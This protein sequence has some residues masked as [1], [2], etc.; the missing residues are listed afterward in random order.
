MIRL[1]ITIYLLLL[2]PTLILAAPINVYVRL[3]DPVLAKSVSEFNNELKRRGIFERYGFEP[4]L[5]RHPLHA[6]LYL[7]TYSKAR[8]EEVVEVA[9]RLACHS[10]P[11][12]LEITGLS[13]TNTNFVMLNIDNEAMPQ[14]PPLQQLS[15]MATLKLA[16]LR[17]Y[18]AHI[19]DWV[20]SIP[21]KRKAFER[22]GSPN[23]FF[24]F[25]PHI[26]LMAPVLKEGERSHAFRG[27]VQTVIDA[28]GFP[29]LTLKPTVLGV[30]YADEQGQITKEIA[31]F[32]LATC[33]D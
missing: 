27:E 21:A 23:V 12:R 14:N 3:D 20:K 2:V 29:Y 6:T 24:E 22:Y 28:W 7:A 33:P 18:N 9:R 32:E 13:L 4:F 17:D 5:N 16:G 10:L 15:D 1:C 31:H 11:V 30:G 19:P 25:N 26:S 8:A